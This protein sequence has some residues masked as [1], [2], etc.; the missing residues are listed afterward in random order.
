M[1]IVSVLYF[2]YLKPNI[3]S[4]VFILLT[5]RQRWLEKVGRQK[6][7]EMSLEQESVQDN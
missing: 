2:T 6:K 7:S 4:K 3:S 1:L 5:W